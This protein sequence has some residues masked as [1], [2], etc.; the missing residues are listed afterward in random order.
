MSRMVCAAAL[1]PCHNVVQRQS[2]V[3]KYK[4]NVRLSACCEVAG[5]PAD[6]VSQSIV[7][8]V[9][10]VISGVREI[11]QQQV[12]QEAS[13]RMADRRPG[14]HRAPLVLP[15]GSG[16]A[17]AHVGHGLQRTI[18]AVW[19][20]SPVRGSM[21]PAA[22]PTMRRWSSKVVVR[23]CEPSRRAA[24]FMRSICSPGPHSDQHAGEQ[25]CVLL[26]PG[27]QKMHDSLIRKLAGTWSLP[28][29]LVLM[30]G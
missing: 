28:W 17:D 29:H 26:I 12:L 6:P 21:W 8:L 16:Y 30:P 4:I 7:L 22:S 11:H 23:P 1:P 14:A 19:M 10:S 9:L 13:V 25:D 15:C 20:P 24:A 3:I 5:K 2:I 18:I 27:A